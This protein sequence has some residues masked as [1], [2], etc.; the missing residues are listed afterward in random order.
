M[1][2]FAGLGL[3]KSKDTI[4]QID[5]RATETQQFSLADSVC[6]PQSQQSTPP[7]LTPCLLAECI[8]LRLF[9]E[10]LTHIAL[11]ITAPEKALVLLCK[12]Q[13]PAKL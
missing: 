5:L 2:G 4:S 13:I 10:S 3:M 9:D 1:T 8:V 12:Q 6:V 11:L 7:K